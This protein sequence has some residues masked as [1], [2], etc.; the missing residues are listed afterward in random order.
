MPPP[1]RRHSCRAWQFTEPVDVPVV[2]AANSPD[3]AAPKRISLPSKLPP[4]CCAR[5]LLGDTDIVELRVAGRLEPD[6]DPGRRDPEDE[7]R[8][9]HR[10]A[11]TVCPSPACRTCTSSANGITSRKKICERVGE[12][13]GALER[14]GRVR[15]EETAAVGAEL[16]DRLLARD[17]TARDASAPRPATVCAVGVAGEVLDHALAHEHERG[18]E[19]QGQQDAN[20]RS[21]SG[22]PRSCRSSRCGGGRAHGSAR[23]PPPGRRPPR[24]SSAPPSPAIWVRWLIV[25]SPDVVLPVRV[26]READCGVE[27]QRRRHCLDI[28]RIERKQA[29][30]RAAARRGKGSIRR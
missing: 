8:R 22:R 18:D 1:R 15:V 13:V 20:R 19:R 25:D 29:P 27:R 24:G 14:M 2:E 23:P 5:H 28:G 10:T 30:G 3:A 12:A 21:W 16:L 4:D 17:R 26:G 9:E 6:R 11:L 7:H